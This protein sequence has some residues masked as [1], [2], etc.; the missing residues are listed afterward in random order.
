LLLDQETQLDFLFSIVF[1]Y[2]GTV[3]LY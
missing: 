2:R 3:Q 1:F